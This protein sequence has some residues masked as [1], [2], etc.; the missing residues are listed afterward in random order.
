MYKRFAGVGLLIESELER[1][2]GRSMEQ[3]EL[4]QRNSPLHSTGYARLLRPLKIIEWSLIVLAGGSY[5]VLLVTGTIHFNAALTILSIFLSLITILLIVEGGIR[6]KQGQ[7]NKTSGEATPSKGAHPIIGILGGAMLVLLA[8]LVF[9][10]ANGLYFLAISVLLAFALS[11]LLILLVLVVRL[12]LR[13][14]V[15]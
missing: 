8:V 6:L 13:L 15:F 10:N 5:L 12:F 2:E 1:K 7:L 14:G 3:Q 4:E 11:G 9:L